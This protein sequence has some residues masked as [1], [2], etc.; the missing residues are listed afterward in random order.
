MVNLWCNYGLNVVKI[1]SKCGQNMVNLVRIW[2]TYPHNLIIK[3]IFIRILRRCILD[4]VSFE[5]RNEEW[6]HLIHIT[7]T[8]MTS[9]SSSQQHHHLPPPDEEDE[10]E[11]WDG[12]G[13]GDVDVEGDDDDDVMTKKEEEDGDDDVMMMV[14]GEDG[15]EDDDGYDGFPTGG[16]NLYQR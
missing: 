11:M 8:S 15:E 1:W 5:H 14:K 6:T 3:S 13:V 12:W 4:D 7:S 9:S 2:C 16:V 10:E